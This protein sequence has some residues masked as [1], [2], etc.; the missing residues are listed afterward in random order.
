MVWNEDQW[1]LDTGNYSNDTYTAG[2]TTTY[3]RRTG[4]G[5][6]GAVFNVDDASLGSGTS[7]WYTN[8]VYLRPTD[9]GASGQ[10]IFGYYTHT[11]SGGYISTISLSWPAGITI[12]AKNGANKKTTNRERNDDRLKVTR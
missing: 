5:G 6:P 1:D 7:G 2:P 11:W 9:S 8:G 4:V 3:N 12:T 10:E